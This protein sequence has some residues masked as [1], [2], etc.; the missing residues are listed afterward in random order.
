MQHSVALPLKLLH[1]TK[2]IQVPASPAEL[3]DRVALV[4][5]TPRERLVAALSD[6]PKTVAQL[7]TEFGLSQPT[8]LEQVRRALRDG[9]IAEV[10]VAPQQRRF[11]GERYYAPAVPVIS[12]IDR[13]LLET[14]CR[15]IADHMAGALLQSRADLLAAFSLTHLAQQGWEPDDL[16]PYLQET[17]FRLTLEQ[18]AHVVTPTSLPAH[19]LA[20]VEEFVEDEQPHQSDQDREEGIA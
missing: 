1:W 6:Q 10:D 17:I 4:A 8:M 5:P 12:Q 2:Q 11:P 9:L 3:R 20:W 13:E 14:A 16:W 7:A 18:V 19:G 15:P